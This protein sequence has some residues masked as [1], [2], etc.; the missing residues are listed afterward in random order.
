MLDIDRFKLRFGPYHSP[1]CKVGGWVTCAV[2]GRV[3]VTGIS[4]APIPWPMTRRPEGGGRAFLI[5]VGDLKRAL[6]RESA[7]AVG[8]W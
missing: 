5:V 8:H 7:Q 6:R 1:R 4:D 2:R 3:K